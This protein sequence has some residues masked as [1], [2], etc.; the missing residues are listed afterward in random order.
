MEAYIHARLI[1][2]SNQTEGVEG[3]FR[4]LTDRGTVLRLWAFYMDQPDLEEILDS[5]SG[6]G[7]L[8]ISL[9][10]GDVRLANDAGM[11][12]QHLGGHTWD[13]PLVVA[14]PATEWEESCE[15]GVFETIY[16]PPFKPPIDSGLVAGVS[17]EGRLI[18]SYSEYIKG[19]SVEDFLSKYPPGTRLTVR[20][21]RA[22]LIAFIEDT[23]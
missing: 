17:T 18:F 13:F 23:D 15:R 16:I 6:R 2:V 12:L 1:D 14:G 9:E 11:E 19:L 21:P 8:V 20:H 5:E 7:H 4:F 3:W 22:R 10:L